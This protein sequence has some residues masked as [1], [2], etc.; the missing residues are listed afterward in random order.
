[1]SRFT[2]K[3]DVK[4]TKIFKGAGVAAG[5][6]A[7]TYLLGTLDVLDVDAITPVYVALMASL[8]NV[9]KVFMERK[10]KEYDT[11]DTK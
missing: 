4:L 3:L 7:L 6:A 10:A 8:L 2:Y 5:G 9:L 1:M 11:N